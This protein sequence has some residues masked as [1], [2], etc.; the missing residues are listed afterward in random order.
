MIK[1]TYQEIEN[2]SVF[3]RLQYIA[4]DASHKGRSR[5][6]KSTTEVGCSIYSDAGE[7]YAGCNYDFDFGKVV[8][9]EECAIT[10]MIINGSFNNELIDTMYIY[11]DKFEHFSSCGDCRDKMKRFSNDPEMSVY[12]DNGKY[13][14]MYR[15]NELLPFYP[16]RKENAV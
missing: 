2:N 8:H 4:K 14:V 12:L 6:L 15:L 1:V 16:E 11:C 5:F 10:N 3:R 9:A 7:F 13:V